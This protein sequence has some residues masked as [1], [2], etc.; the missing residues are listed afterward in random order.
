MYC[1]F[2]VPLSWQL[3]DSFYLTVFHTLSVDLVGLSFFFTTSFISVN[4]LFPACK[5]TYN[6][7]FCR[8]HSYNS[9]SH[10][11]TWWD[12]LHAFGISLFQ[13]NTT[14]HYTMCMLSTSSKCTPQWKPEVKCHSIILYLGKLCVSVKTYQCCDK[15]FL[16]CF[17]KLAHPTT[18]EKKISAAGPPVNSRSAKILLLHQNQQ[19]KPFYSI[20]SDLQSLAKNFFNLVRVCQVRIYGIGF[21]DS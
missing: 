7:N 18:L 21:Q 5:W 15:D 2:N 1:H 8:M 20:N 14:K 17:E 10:L 11:S 9:L 3:G 19:C 12:R 4:P 6:A 13:N 16:A